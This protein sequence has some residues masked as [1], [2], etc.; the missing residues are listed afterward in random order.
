MSRGYYQ[1]IFRNYKKLFFTATYPEIYFT[2]LSISIRQ[3]IHNQ[4]NE[5]V[6]KY[7]AV[8]WTL[9][10]LRKTNCCYKMINFSLRELKFSGNMYFSYIE[11]IAL[12][13]VGKVLSLQRND[14]KVTYLVFKNS[15]LKNYHINR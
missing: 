8:F 9:E 15:I 7:E 13:K 3:S 14:K 2:R 4:L 10:K 5:H 11:R 6:H 1:N 12:A